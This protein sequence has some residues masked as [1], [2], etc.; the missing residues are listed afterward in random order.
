MAV[1]SISKLFFTYW[2]VFFVLLDVSISV[3]HGQKARTLHFAKRSVD[4]QFGERTMVIEADLSSRT[5][6]DNSKVVD[7]LRRSVRSATSPGSHTPVET[8]AQLN[9]SH[10]QMIV[11]W[12]GIGSDVIIALA[13]D[14][15]PRSTSSSQ[16]FISFNY[17]R[18]FSNQNSIMY[19]D[20]PNFTPVIN[21]YFNCKT[22]NSY[23]IFADVVHNLIFTTTDYGKT[24]QSHRVPFRPKT[25]AIHPNK[26]YIV[27]GMDDE[28]DS[29][30]RLYLSQ[31]FGENWNLLQSGVKSFFWG[32]PPYD[33]DTDIY[34]ERQQFD[35]GFSVLKSSNY[36]DSIQTILT[37]VEDFDVRGEYLFATRKPHLFGS[38][39]NGTLQFWVSYKRG[40]F[41]N[42]EFSHNAPRMDFFVADASEDQIFLCVN[43]NRTSSHL[44]ISDA[45]GSK[46]TLSLENIVYFNPKG[47]H[48]NSWL[49]FFTEE[50]FADIHKVDGLRGVY[51]AS[52]FINS[53]FSAEN[54]RS[55]IT[56]DKGG[57]WQLVRAPR[58]DQN[59]KSTN[60]SISA[61]CSLHLSQ[62]FQR[63]HPGSRWVP[64][65]SKKSAPGIIMAT[66]IVGT[67]M[68]RDPDVYLSTDAG[69]TWH[70]ILDDNYHFQFGDHGGVLV[71]IK[72][73][74]TTDEVF[75]STDEGE[76][77]QVAKFHDEKIRVY[78]VLTEPG[79]K[80]AVFSIFGSH[81]ARHSWLIIQLNLTDVFTYNQ[82][83]DDDYKP[84]SFPDQP[85][86]AG[87]ILGKKIVFQRRTAH[88]NCYNGRDYVR[89]VTEKNCTCT[90]EDFECD[91]GFDWSRDPFE[92]FMKCNPDPNSGIEINKVP[93]PCPPG[94]Y[95]QYSRGYRKVVG[96]TCHGGEESKYA[97]LRYSCP[98]RELPEFILYSTKT[99]IRRYLFGDNR[100]EVIFSNSSLIGEIS[101][102]DFDYSENCIIW[103]DVLKDKINRLCLDGHHTVETF[104]SRGLNTVESIAYDW[105]AGNIYWV[106]A[107]FKQINVA[108][109]DGRYQAT[110]FNA[111]KLDLPRAV[112][113]DTHYGWMYWTDWSSSRPRI[114][115]AYMDG[116]PSSYSAI[117][118]DN[119][120]VHWPNGITIDHM[121]DRIY[122][123]DG[124]LHH[125]A[126]AKLDGSNARVLVQGS[127][128]A[129]HPYSIGVYKN[130]VYWTDWQKRSLMSSD[131]TTNTYIAPV[132]NNLNSVMDL[133][134]VHNTSQHSISACS[135][136]NGHCSQLCLPHPQ[137]QDMTQKNRTC[138]CDDRSGYL[139]QINDGNQKCT[140]LNGTL[141]NG[142]CVHRNSSGCGLNE[143]QCINDSHCIPSTWLC[144][145]DEDCSDGSDEKDCR[146]STCSHEQ[147]TCVSN[148]KCI[149]M[150]WRCDYD[151]DCGDGSD[152]ESCEYRNCTKNEFRCDNGR[153]IVKTW[154]CDYD[155]DCH[156]GSDEKLCNYNVTCR[157]DEFHC[158]SHN[159]QCVPSSR[160][161]D[162]I[163]DCGD[164]S[165]E[166]N[167]NSTVCVGSNRFS[168]KNGKCIEKSWVCDGMNDCNDGGHGSDEDN[169]TVTT[170]SPMTTTPSR[171]YNCRSDEFMCHDGRCIS[172]LFYC[173]GVPDCYDSSDEANCV[174]HRPSVHPNTTT[175]PCLFDMFRC[176]N[177]RCV[178]MW[179]R[180]DGRDNCGDN[181]DEYNCRTTSPSPPTCAVGTFSCDV[182]YDPK[183]IP[184]SWV[185]DDAADCTD[186]TD[187]KDCGGSQHCGVGYFRCINEGG[188]IPRNKL[189][190]G[191]QDCT[192]GTD[193]GVGCHNHST[194]RPPASFTCQ[195]DIY[196]TCTL[197]RRCVLYMDLCVNPCYEASLCNSPK[198]EKL[199]WGYF[200]VFDV[201]AHNDHGTGPNKT[202]S[203]KAPGQLTVMWDSPPGAP[204]GTEYTVYYSYNPTDLEDRNIAKKA[205]RES[206]T[207]KNNM[208]ITD[209][210]SCESYSF[211]IAITSPGICPLSP[212]HTRQI[213]PD[214]GGK[215]EELHFSP[216]DATSG[217][218]TWQA[219]CPIQIL[220]VTYEIF[221]KRT[222]FNT[223][224]VHY[225]Q[226]AK[227]VYLMNTTNTSV[228]VSPK[229]GLK[230][231]YK[232]RVAAYQGY[233]GQFSYIVDVASSMIISEP[234][235]NTIV[236]SKTNVIAIAVSVS[237]VVIAL[238]V[239]LSFFVIR[240]RRLQRSFLAFA[241]SHYDTRSGTTTFT[242][243]N[244]LDEDEDSPM[245]RGFSD[246]E[247]LVIA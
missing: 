167:C 145:H 56:F 209:L 187:E 96:D 158:V 127:Y 235:K 191:R 195:S 236:L 32:V 246:D 59:G 190:D 171:R 239:V 234:A 54:Q 223:N 88:S 1:C 43:H 5:V 176:N 58:Y 46:F 165:D 157:D 106:D 116:T 53:S 31:N 104:I 44:Y 77:W 97:P 71:A 13:K 20:Y 126:S 222:E 134:I 143:I 109:K 200:Y 98:V 172:W 216:I 68:K 89:Q 36:F 210:R 65:L 199:C 136:D 177:G 2:L 123:T 173:D 230:S 149:P 121:T 50:S 78:G 139:S 23:Y 119:S 107:T 153:C 30:K 138:R 244:E 4:S 208:V 137:L 67:N 129:P 64:I 168:C 95:F 117:V 69:F 16:L 28:K 99:E 102:V 128:Y 115:R 229:P 22:Y 131:K 213:G 101:A 49:R 100:D 228:I 240:H 174:T 111:T 83:K 10:S 182:D 63:L 93:T 227:F 62:E 166:T 202:V 147:F 180:C 74:T 76:N 160:R 51:I 40:R 91:L 188:C 186:E 156:D 38:R 242:A 203:Y 35:G 110:L 70:M 7:Y 243:A 61:N 12:A 146:Y 15:H 241:N 221:E 125:I 170:M 238:V 179:L 183:C 57:E 29:E 226:D 232:V 81:V 214:V 201:Q 21:Q 112:T 206:V 218:L 175:R 103:A 150:R 162:G 142:E 148:S 122:W 24:F 6:S 86:F 17:G 52:Q 245:I 108:S 66:G 80:T 211:R 178:G 204:T 124:Y 224:M 231:S 48:K 207:D 114:A 144:D 84:W 155:D 39:D 205:F 164:G 140:C 47:A 9:D 237:V 14:P 181:S 192:D 132:V 87:C 169:C 85:P 79:E 184:Q 11:H 198:V 42:A 45:T 161:C 185:C 163:R 154:Q 82:C 215:P 219:P 152:E 94:Q 120:F 73:F 90:R 105:T 233:P 8:F 212:V 196:F 217:K 220:T 75:Y 37:D 60:C 41:M 151:D 3:R 118:T 194:V 25:I 135:R 27:L 34:V 26:P 130:M 19:R 33:G 133:K 18:N 55:L 141:I 159:P 247:P 193:E 225:H 189:C 197:S 72:Q 92:Y 113:L